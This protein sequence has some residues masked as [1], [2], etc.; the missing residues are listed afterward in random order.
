MHNAIPSAMDVAVTA[1]TKARAVM[2]SATAVKSVVTKPDWQTMPLSKACCKM[3]K[4][5]RQR[6]RLQSTVARRKPGSA[7]SAV[8]AAHAI[9]TDV[10]AVAKTVTARSQRMP[11]Q[12]ISQRRLMRLPL[13]RPLSL[14]HLAQRGLLS[15]SRLRVMSSHAAAAILSVQQ[16]KSRQP[17]AQ[18]MRQLLRMP[19]QL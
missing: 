6:S 5:M 11:R 18:Q 10:I 17:P 4:A 13:Q 14:S 2:V 7:K 15:M 1:A 16:G 12:G 3:P 9:A 19:M 8:S